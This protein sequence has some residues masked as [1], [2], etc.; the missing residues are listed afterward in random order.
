MPQRDEYQNFF[1]EIA[2]SAINLPVSV[3]NE[4]AGMVQRT[5][6]SQTLGV[7]QSQI[8]GLPIQHPLLDQ[9]LPGVNTIGGIENALQRSIIPQ[10]L[11]MTQRVT[12][13]RGSTDPTSIFSDLY[14]GTFNAAQTFQPTHNGRPTT[15]AHYATRQAFQAGST[16]HRREFRGVS[17]DQFV[18]DDGDLMNNA[19]S[20]LVSPG[21]EDDYVPGGATAPYTTPAK[22]WFDPLAKVEH[23]IPSPFYAPKGQRFLVGGQLN[24]NLS[25]VPR[26]GL[27]QVSI[28]PRQMQSYVS[29]VASNTE[30]FNTQPTQVRGFLRQTAE[31]LRGGGFISTDEEVLGAVAGADEALIETMIGNGADRFDFTGVSINRGALAYAPRAKSLSGFIRKVASTD[32]A[33]AG[34]VYLQSAAQG[35]IA[36]SDIRRIPVPSGDK[37]LGEYVTNNFDELTDAMS[38]I[39]QGYGYT[40]TRPEDLQQVVEQLRATNPTAIQAG[41]Q[42]AEGRMM[43]V[44]LEDTTTYN[45]GRQAVRQ[46]TIAAERAQMV[47][48]GLSEPVQAP[49]INN[50]PAVPEPEAPPVRTLSRNNYT[51]PEPQAPASP[52]ITIGG[53][54]VQTHQ[55]ANG[56][57]GWDEPVVSGAGNGQPP[58]N[59]PPTAVASPEEPEPNFNAPA[60]QA[61]A[62]AVA[63]NS[64][65]FAAPAQGSVST[66]RTR[67]QE[68][69]SWIQQNHP[70]FQF[71]RG[72]SAELKRLKQDPEFAARHKAIM[73]DVRMTGKVGGTSVLDEVISQNNAVTSGLASSSPAV[74]STAGVMASSNGSRGGGGQPPIATTSAPVEPED[75]FW[76]S[77]D[78]STQP[79]Y[80]ELR[81]QNEQDAAAFTPQAQ[82]ANTPV[83]EQ[84]F[85]ARS[86]E[87][88]AEQRTAAGRAL[89]NA[90]QSAQMMSQMIEAAQTQM[91]SITAARVYGNGSYHGNY[92]FY[93]QERGEFV[94]PNTGMATI[95][96]GTMQRGKDIYDEAMSG[97]FEKGG[98]EGLTNKEF[99]ATLHKRVQQG[100]Q[101]IVDGTVEEMI[102]ASPESAA[103]AKSVG[104]QLRTVAGDLL[105]HGDAELR[106]ATGSSRIG[107]TNMSSVRAYGKGLKALY[108]DQSPAGQA[109]KERVDE[110][111]G[112]DAVANGP[113]RTIIAGD[114]SWDVGRVDGGGPGGG[115]GRM[116][117]FF[118][119]LYST[120]LGHVMM[121]QFMSSMAW[122]STGGAVLDTAQTWATQQ[123]QYAPFAT[124]G[125]GD[126]GA[127]EMAMARQEMGANQMGRLAYEQYGSLREL[128]YVAGNLPG[129]D[130]I[131][132][133]G[134]DL[135]MGLGAGLYAGIGTWAAGTAL[136]A[137]APAAGAALVGAAGP[138]G[139]A[140]AATVA[141]PALAM[142]GAN[143]ALGFDS[144]E[145]Y[146][147][148]NLLAGSAM[149]GA[150][151]S[152]DKV[153][154]AGNQVGNLLT[155]GL[156]GNSIF[157]MG[158]L[159]EGIA[160]KY[161]MSAQEFVQSS[162]VGDV[163]GEKNVEWLFEGRSDKA[164]NARKL[165]EE[166]QGETG[167]KEDVVLKGVAALNVAFG[168]LESESQHK[169]AVQISKRASELGMD[170]GSL[171][172]DAGNIAQMRG[173]Q[174]GTA[175]FEQV[176]VDFAN[177][178]QVEQ[179]KTTV[180]ASR[181]FQ[182]YAQWVPYLS[183]GNAEGYQLYEQLGGT[184]MAQTQAIQSI[185]SQSQMNG[186]NLTP[187]TA[188][189]LATTANSMAPFRA[190]DVAGMASSMFQMGAGSFT[191][192]FSDLASSVQSGQ[193][194][195][196]LSDAG[197]L[198]TGAIT[199]Q[200]GNQSDTLNF[201]KGVTSGNAYALSDYGRMAGI[202][203]LQQLDPNGLQT[204]LKDMSGLLAYANQNILNKPNLTGAQT[205][206]GLGMTFSSTDQGALLEGGQWGYQQSYVNQTN[207][208]Q[209]QGL[210]LQANQLAYQKQTM[211]EGWG[212]EDATMGEQ[213]SS[214][215]RGFAFQ[216]TMMDTQWRHR[217]EDVAFTEQ[218]RGLS[219]ENSTWTRDF[220][221]QTSLMKRDW[222]RED[223][224]FNTQMRQLSFGWN[225]EDMD[226][227]IKR[228]SG[229]ERSLLIRQRDRATMSENLQSGQAETQFERQEELWA[230]E[231]ERYKKGVEFNENMMQ[232][233]DERWQLNLRQAEEI[234]NLN[235]GHLAEEME[236]AT[237]LHGLRIEM[238]NLQRER[239]Q[240][241]LRNSEQSLSIQKQMTTLQN[242]YAN[243]MTIMSH[244]QTEMEASL[245]KITSYSPAFS[246]MLGDFLSFLEDAS[247]VSVPTSGSR[248]A[249]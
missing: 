146:S 234:Y 165:T 225:M 231:D 149:Q 109:L 245:R 105:S 110:L 46:A 138:V 18:N 200:G 7:P 237:T 158:K 224:Q 216:G 190:M 86:R 103:Q 124:F 45:Q 223:Y 199:T 144:Y 204:G 101:K 217:Q 76:T 126:P 91:S 147:V 28:T 20:A 52:Q 176:A 134:N 17:I 195:F 137:V 183:G 87:L 159:Q 240:E 85:A 135:K 40:P 99:A 148:K 73:D 108:A 180:K 6:S 88:V 21:F 167:L 67:A 169:S 11:G 178:S 4:L 116:G 156:Y 42:I 173:I 66:T 175:E 213:W 111:G 207:A 33:T 100:I 219:R 160:E 30:L 115:G 130:N 44:R 132:R 5:Y 215:L 107:D 233:E 139:L 37:N 2:A 12:E 162:W 196:N 29:N 244:T 64:V 128:G 90:P 79:S 92:G 142:T 248:L 80:D 192:N 198:A 185:F 197:N 249:K 161:G 205:L 120:P 136:G 61:A 50:T 202:G 220:D 247:R 171:I 102:K 59:N 77:R 15:F 114:Q 54:P 36:P 227:Q 182:K 179:Q 209:M 187:Q 63:S 62:S 206:T 27:H 194:G 153:A 214:Q 75:N 150:M 113:Q 60:S 201:L 19:P 57:W 208:L 48:M 104:Q 229:Y 177:L 127:S 218:E 106:Q 47:Q 172:S 117:N 188:Q 181:D 235:K 221:Y 239:Q 41:E 145:G 246:R 236:S 9:H 74:A 22:H 72:R 210:N 121:A 23:N 242:E 118:K 55:G 65:P 35:L 238:E 166:I 122:K 203:V 58:S 69:A 71:G 83:S 155:A 170:V 70:E 186:V 84:Q 94:S 228:S 154:A 222:S 16:T 26:E 125:G 25:F 31:G 129:G 151:V 174:T 143:A 81:W 189:Q 82:S 141:A 34:A 43:G 163:I 1:D 164:E 14:A 131:L 95:T 8:P 89:R 78:G 93:N 68:A 3:Q 32:P 98:F 211:Y 38:V 140:V 97:A 49:V 243:N 96:S 112:L 51:R 10:L 212:I 24:P 39:E 123:Q 191:G 184:N 230:R 232:L 13:N 157:G 226:E 53:E 241:Q 56:R 119:S 133:A 193:F 152:H 168:G